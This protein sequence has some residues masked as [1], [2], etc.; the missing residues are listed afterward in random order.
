MSRTHPLP[1]LRGVLL[2]V[3]LSVMILPLGAV[4]FFRIFENELVRQTE[5]ELIAQSAVMGATLRHLLR[6]PEDPTPDPVPVEPRPIFPVVDLA[7]PLEPPRPDARPVLTQPDLR[8]TDAARIMTRIMRDTQTVT[9]AGMRL[10]DPTGTVIA[11]REE[12]GLSL[13]HVPEVRQALDGTYAAVIRRRISDEPRPPIYS[14]SRGTDIRVFT[15]FPVHENE[16]LLGVVYLSRTPPSILKRL[17]DVRREVAL[18]GLTLLTVTV[19]LGLLV[20]SAIARPIRAL[21]LHVERVRR[22]EERAVRPI[23]HPVTREVA[24]LSESFA[25]MSE[26]L[27]ER[28]DYI[29]RFAS[30]VSHEFNTPLAAMQGALELLRDHLDTMEPAR[31]R[32]FLDNLTADT[33]RMK[34]LVVRLLELA[35]A[36]ALEPSQEHSNLG[37]VLRDVDSAFRDRGLRVRGADAADSTALPMAAEAVAIVLSNLAE[38]SLRHGADLLTVSATSQ[39]SGLILLA[40]DNGQ[41][42]L[43]ANR[44]KIFTPFFTTSRSN[45]GTGLGLEI[46]RSILR[47]HG[48]RID[49]H[50]P[51]PETGAVFRLEFPTRPHDAPN[52]RTPFQP[53]P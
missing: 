39:D 15:A 25:A 38:N 20:S 2:L 27:A 52:A 53:R 50:D 21:L 44:D 49:L 31:A 34:R 12:V 36:D 24:R 35:R 32:S 6:A 29:R 23:A 4:Y 3:L 46:C 19:L 33:E 7:Q 22:G 26:A 43:P 9:L 37:S 51:Q 18:A 1:S 13:A 11:G 10:L 40:R 41:G 14:I 45:G 30:H 42:I 48:A 5:Q 8:L 16:R 17:H 47:A 28:G